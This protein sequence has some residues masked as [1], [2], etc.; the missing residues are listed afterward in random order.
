MQFL[1]GGTMKGVEYDLAMLDYD[2]VNIQNDLNGIDV[3]S[4]QRI[5]FS[6]ATWL[7]E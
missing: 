5:V 4:N 1:G 7:T 6:Q 3:L 2:Q